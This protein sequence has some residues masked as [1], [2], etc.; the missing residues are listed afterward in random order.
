MRILCMQARQRYI[1]ITVQHSD[2]QHIHIYEH[3]GNKTVYTIYIWCT[4]YWLR[5]WSRNVL[6][7]L[8]VWFW[9]VL[10]CNALYRITT[11]AVLRQ[12]NCLIS[13]RYRYIFYIYRVH[14]YRGFLFKNSVIVTLHVIDVL[15]VYN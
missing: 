13:L 15:I 10:Y 8:F 11:D 6:C 4:V 1:Y 7:C 14:C 12:H 5:R 3:D 2:T 9:M